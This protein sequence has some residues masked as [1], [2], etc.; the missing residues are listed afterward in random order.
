MLRLPPSDVSSVGGLGR[1]TIDNEWR[2]QKNLRHER[3]NAFK[4]PIED[5]KE[6]VLR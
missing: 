6:E 1:V 4:S 3:V 5:F 2:M